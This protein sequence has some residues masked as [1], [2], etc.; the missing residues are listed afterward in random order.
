M[1]RK[2]LTAQP[3]TAHD[4]RAVLAALHLMRD[5]LQAT[6]TLPEG[7]YEIATGG[8]RAPLPDHRQVD[9]I[10]ARIDLTSSPLAQAVQALQVC[11]AALEAKPCFGIPSLPFELRDSYKVLAW[12]GKLIPSLKA[13]TASPAKVAP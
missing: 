3:M 2:Q 13:E 9:Q 1:S 7:A 11:E 6:G 8:G 4:Q 5:R 12:I 10:I